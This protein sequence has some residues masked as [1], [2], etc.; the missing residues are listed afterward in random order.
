MLGLIICQLFLQMSTV[1]IVKN[2]V[3]LYFSYNP[4]IYNATSK[5][6]FLFNICPDWA[7]GFLMIF[8]LFAW[9]EEQT[10]FLNFII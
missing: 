5:N 7:P 10:E 9:K 2:I 6:S 3:S 8:I 4:M 1:M